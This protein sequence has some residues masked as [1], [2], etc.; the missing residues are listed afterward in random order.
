MDMCESSPILIDHN[1]FPSIRKKEEKTFKF[2]F[3]LGPEVQV[4]VYHSPT[5]HYQSKS[6]VDF[7]I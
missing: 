7:A 5:T 2:R 4:H 6:A 3:A 1:A